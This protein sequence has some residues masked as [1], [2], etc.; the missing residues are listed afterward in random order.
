MRKLLFSTLLVMSFSQAGIMDFFSTSD[1]S[2]TSAIDVVEEVRNI[3]ATDPE[4][5]GSNIKTMFAGESRD[6]SFF[7]GISSTS[8]LLPGLIG[9]NEITASCLY[10]FSAS[11][12]VGLHVGYVIAKAEYGTPLVPDEI[13]DTRYDM[14][15]NYRIP[16][17]SR[18]LHAT[19]EVDTYDDGVH[20][21]PRIGLL[22]VIDRVHFFSFSS[23]HKFER[24]N[25]ISYSYL[26]WSL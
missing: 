25:R 26:F 9:H 7:V 6:F 3:D 10:D 16:W 8:D 19:F 24:V 20:V 2:Q 12:S 5:I 4:S 21:D 18:N 22:Y 17:F 11:W 13:S 14:F 1:K 23:A 15:V